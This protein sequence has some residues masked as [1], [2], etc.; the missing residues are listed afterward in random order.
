MR[1]KVFVIAMFSRR[2]PAGS[3]SLINDIV[4]LGNFG[5]FSAH[6][7]IGLLFRDG[8]PI[9]SVTLHIAMTLTGIPIRA[10]AFPKSHNIFTRFIAASASRSSA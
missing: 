9:S 1:G 4:P 10:N 5:T 6:F 3:G 7:S 8:V 2:D